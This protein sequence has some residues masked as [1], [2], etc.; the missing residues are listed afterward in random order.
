MVWRIESGPLAWAYP[1][2]ITWAVRVTVRPS[3]R[4][5]SRGS[6]GGRPRT[7]I[8]N[9]PKRNQV[10]SARNL[11]SHGR[12]RRNHKAA[13]RKTAIAIDHHEGGRQARRPT[14][15]PREKTSAAQNNGWRGGGSSRITGPPRLA[16]SAV[17]RA[18]VSQFCH[19]LF[20]H[21]TILKKWG[22][23]TALDAQRRLTS[24]HLPA[25]RR[26]WAAVKVV[27]GLAA[28]PIRYEK[29][30]EKDRIS[31]LA[32]YDNRRK[33]RARGRGP[34]LPD[35]T[36]HN[37]CVALRV[38]PENVSPLCRPRCGEGPGRPSQD[39][40]AP[41]GFS[42]IPRFACQPLSRSQA[43]SVA[44]QAGMY[45][46]ALQQKCDESSWRAEPQTIRHR[47]T[48]RGQGLRRRRW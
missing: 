15:S 14:Q 32:R 38:P 27:S 7:W 11:A 41:A 10:A 43:H 2:L 18:R 3:E 36:R 4:V 26:N 48:S 34:A 35:R 20:C 40:Y 1:S 37:G 42:G 39:V 33:P 8:R 21:E 9:A 23:S 22:R 44:G 47:H 25:S 16:Q 28:L 29:F 5:G 31:A 45:V 6:S 46:T 19:A 12:R 17:F 24:G 13:T 30:A